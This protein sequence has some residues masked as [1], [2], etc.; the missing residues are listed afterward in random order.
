[1]D[2]DEKKKLAEWIGIKTGI[3][4][5]GHDVGREGVRTNGELSEWGYWDPNT[6]HYQFSEV[7]ERLEP[8]Q[9]ELIFKKFDAYKDPG[10]WTNALLRRLDN[11]ME[12]VMEALNLK[13]D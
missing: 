3:I 5:C 4:M 10:N 7:F 9:K 8:H 2:I 1:M 12:A 11:V 6:K 13:L